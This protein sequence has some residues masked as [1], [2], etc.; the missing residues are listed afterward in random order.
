MSPLPVRRK[1]LPTDNQFTIDAPENGCWWRYLD[2]EEL[3]FFTCHPEKYGLPAIPEKPGLP[4]I[5][6]ALNC[7]KMKGNLC[8]KFAKSKAYAGQYVTGRTGEKYL[9]VP[10]AE[11]SETEYEQPPNLELMLILGEAVIRVG[12]LED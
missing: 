6:E 3:D 4:A 7:T 5:P 12:I 11:L 10:R 1:T 9:R 2:K 8:Q